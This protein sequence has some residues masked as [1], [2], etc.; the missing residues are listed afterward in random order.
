MMI[1]RT[2]LGAAL[3][4]GLLAAPLAARAQ[5]AAKVPRVGLLGTATP[6]LMAPWITAFRDGLREHGYVERQNVD[7]EYRW[8]EGKPER[9]PGL[10]AELVRL[11]VDVIVTSGP[12]A[13]RAA[14]RATSTI[15]IVMAIIDDPVDQ[16]FVSSFGRPGGNLTGLSFQDPDLAV[17]RLQLLHEAIP[18]VIRVAALW[19]S[20][21]FRPT[22]MR[23]VERAAPSIGLVLHVLEVRAAT[24]FDR[25]FQAARQQ[26]DQ[27]VIQLASPFFAAHRKTLLALMAKN[28]LP[29]ICQE[30]TF[31][32]D[33]CLMAY[34][35]S[36]PDMFRRAADYVDR[37]LKGAKPAELPVEQASKFELVFNLKTAKALGL[38]IPPSLLLRADQVIQ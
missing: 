26:R 36:F 34:G 28:R 31:V 3:A 22:G 15:P 33:G 13:I 16:G 17:K 19:D 32:V 14:Q 11:K 20:S 12:H 9:F 37:I 38:T 29:A 24:D 18:S 10:V 6:S 8:G 1:I 4:L 2:A 35:P 27:A 30:R 5:Q 21:S 25:A 23:A 7:I